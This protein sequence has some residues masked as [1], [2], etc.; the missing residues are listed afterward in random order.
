MAHTAVYRCDDPRFCM[1]LFDFYG[2]AIET[3]P[4]GCATPSGRCTS[5]DHRAKGWSVEIIV[6]VRTCA[7]VSVVE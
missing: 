7:G 3:E 5:F 4:T 1:V 2:G 6:E